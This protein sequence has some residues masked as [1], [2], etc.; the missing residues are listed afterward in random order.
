VHEPPSDP[1]LLPPAICCL[2]TGPTPASVPMMVDPH[3]GGS[4]GLPVHGTHVP[5]LHAGEGPSGQPQ[6]PVR[7]EETSARYLIWS[8]TLIAALPPQRQAPVQSVPELMATQS[9]FWL[10]DWSNIDGVM[11][12]HVPELDPDVEPEPEGPPE[13]PVDSPPDDPLDPLDPVEE[14]PDDPEPS[15]IVL[16][17]HAA[18]RE[19]TRAAARTV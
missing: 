5:L 19:P 1:L 3:S 8:D 11:V 14:P 17:P 2:H 4:D 16:P 10:H 15:P 9:E 7:T 12:M 6:N 13:D 18:N